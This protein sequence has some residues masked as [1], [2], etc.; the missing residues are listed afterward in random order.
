[1]HLA[2]F[3]TGLV[4]CFSVALDA[5]QTII[6]PRRP[7]GRLRITRFFFLL[8]WTPWSALAPHIH[9][10]RIREQVYSIYGPLSL[11]LLLG[12]WAVLLVFGFALFY[13]AMGSPYR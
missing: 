11:L 1:M 7:A 13:F 3:I 8:T 4:C 9:S 5:F 12:L 2:A 10:K 6:L